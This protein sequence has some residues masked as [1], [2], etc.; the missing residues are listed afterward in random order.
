MAPRKA[1]VT[2][3]PAGLSQFY[4]ILFDTNDYFRVLREVADLLESK[5]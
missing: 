4:K 1:Y 3:E 2:S 5:K